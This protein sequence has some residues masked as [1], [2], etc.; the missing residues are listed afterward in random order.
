MI[1]D[2]D[3]VVPTLGRIMVQGLRSTIEE[4]DLPI[5]VDLIDKGLG[6]HVSYPEMDQRDIMAFKED[7]RAAL[8][9][10]GYD[11]MLVRKMMKLIFGKPDSI[12]EV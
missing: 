8:Y 12:E 5:E 6:V 11:I 9:A 2:P 1:V 3:N 4:L 7:F 10:R